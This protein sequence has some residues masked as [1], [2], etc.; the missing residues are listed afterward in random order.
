MSEKWKNA[1]WIVIIGYVIGLFTRRGYDSMLG[2]PSMIDS[3]IIDID[4]ILYGGSIVFLWLWMLITVS[5]YRELTPLKEAHK[6]WENHYGTDAIK[7]KK[8]SIF[9]RWALNINTYHIIY[10]IVAS[11]VC[12]LLAGGF[13]RAG[14][15]FFLYW[16]VYS[17]VNWYITNG[18]INGKFAKEPEALEESAS[19]H[20]GISG[21]EGKLAVLSLIVASGVSAMMFPKV[22]QSFGGGKPERVIVKLKPGNIVT[23]PSQVSIENKMVDLVFRRGNKFGFRE[24]NWSNN[25]IVVIDGEKI[26]R[27]YIGKGVSQLDPHKLP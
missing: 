7:G 10:Y 8:I 14:L 20:F 11:G 12:F 27:L 26:D 3:P 22:S 2:I 9:I 21:E 16:F 1:G 6:W 13:N 15:Y 24:V 19:F 18:I 23:L 4:S 17:V 25:H 5:V